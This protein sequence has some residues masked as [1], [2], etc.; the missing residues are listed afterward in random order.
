MREF[1]E[2]C[3][4]AG[5]FDEL[6]SVDE[7]RLGEAVFVVRLETSDRRFPLLAKLQAQ[8]RANGASFFAALQTDLD[9][10]EGEG[11][12]LEGAHLH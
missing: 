6:F 4:D 10:A 11:Y 2:V 9:G 5:R 1:L 3:I 8:S 12:V 7:G